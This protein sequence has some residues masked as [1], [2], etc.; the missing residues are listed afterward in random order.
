MRTV[1]V[2]AA[3]VLALGPGVGAARAETVEAPAATPPWLGVSINHQLSVMGGVY[4]V[5]AFDDTPASM[6]GLRAG[7]EILA[8][9]G[10]DVMTGDQLADRVQAHAIGDRLAVRY[11][12]IDPD[13]GGLQLRRCTTTL[14]A[15]ITDRTELLH[16]RVVGRLVPAFSA[17]RVGDG[18]IV[19]DVALRGEVVVVA[20]FS[21]RCD[22]C[23]QAIAEL[24]G[25]VGEV[26]VIAIAGEE[27]G[28]VAAYVQRTGLGGEVA[29]EEGGLVRRYLPDNQEVAFLVVDHRGQVRFAASGLGPESTHV[30]GA[31]FCVERAVRALQKSK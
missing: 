3:T 8:I 30:D 29:F 27:A 28:A 1:G 6:C 21:T 4:V 13:G 7:D 14:A 19:D 5:D 17:Q 22:G 25:A 2:V 16:R 26:R 11:A 10:V 15:R 23:A 18:G 20:L 12:R 31:Q 24:T 9:D